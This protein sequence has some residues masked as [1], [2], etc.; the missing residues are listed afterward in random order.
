MYEI[1]YFVK[2]NYLISF[3]DVR[4]LNIVTLKRY[5]GLYFHILKHHVGRV[6]RL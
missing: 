5:I 3:S 4:T 2:G 1:S 6:F